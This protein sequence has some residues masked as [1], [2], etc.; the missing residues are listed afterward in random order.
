MQASTPP[1]RDPHFDSAARIVLLALIFGIVAFGTDMY[2][3]AFPAIRDAFGAS[4]RTVQFSL[5][6]FLYGNALGQL[7]YG[8]LSDRYGRR[9]L[10][11]AGLGAYTVAS[12]GCALA[13]DMNAFLLCRAIQ[14]AAA[15]GGPVLVRALINDRLERT[16]AARMLALLTGLMAFIAMLTPISG[17]WLVAIGSWQWIFWAMSG[18]GLLLGVC[19]WFRVAETHPPA[20]RLARLGPLEVARGYVEIG[21]SAV[22]WCYVVPPALMFS[23]VFAYVGANSFL[24]I[25][26]LGVPE[27]RHGVTY[28]VAALAYV[29]GSLTSNRL[30]RWLGIER[31]IVT[32]LALGVTAALV[33]VTASGA[34]P[35]SVPL[36]VVPG[37]ATFFATA[38]M[39]PIAISSA[40]S[41]FPHRAGSASAVAGFVQIA[42]AGLGTG[43]SA[44]LVDATTLPLHGFTLACAGAASLAWFGGR[45]T[46]A[47]AGLA[48]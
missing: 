38:L 26:R 33:A 39:V 12:F 37:I 24:L 9:P 46:R 48:G 11:I 15:A 34:L 35:L 27:P 19:T 45:T 21:R 25:D 7:V 31:A 17:G 18:I 43:M 23:S 29:A 4:T 1:A 47:R 40:V 8:P 30:V 10:L 28:A 44:F 3:P 13:T 36:V 6:V 32:G 14:G 2:L 41:L 5:S 22:F 20:L 16:E 42:V